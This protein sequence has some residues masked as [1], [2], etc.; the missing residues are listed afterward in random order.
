MAYRNLGQKAHS[1]IHLIS[2]SGLAAGLPT[3]KIVLSLSLMIGVINLLIEAR[4][5]DYLKRCKN[6]KLFF[7]IALLFV[8]HIIG[9]LWT[10]DFQYAMNDI[11]IKIPLL[12]IPVLFIAKPID[13]FQ[14]KFITNIFLATI[15]ITSLINVSTHQHWI[16]NRQYLD[17]RDLSL[18]GSH[19]RYGILIAIATI[20]VGYEMFSEKK[21]ALSPVFIWLI[22]Y[23]YYSQVLSGVLALFAGVIG[24]IFVWLYSKNRLGGVFAMILLIVSLS[25]GFNSIFQFSDHKNKIDVSKLDQYT[26]LG[27]PYTHEV[28]GGYDING[29]PVMLYICEIE[30]ASE[31][32]K[33]ST[34]SID[35][36]DEKKQPIKYTLIRYLA[37]KGLRKDAEGIKKLSETDVHNI[38][39]GKASPIENENTIVARING[40]QFQLVNKGD[41]NGHSLLQR[42]EYW[43]TGLQILKSHWLTGVGTGDV[44][45]AFDLQYVKD[46]SKLK[47]ERRLRSHNQFLTFAIT[48]GIIGF[49]LFIGLHLVYLKQ[50]LS[51]NRFLSVAFIFIVFATFFIEDTLETQTGV[52]LFA[53]FYSF[54]L[55]DSSNDN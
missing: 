6:Q 2:L 5:S 28:D 12:I 1:V 41:P 48:F 18:F 38:E 33:R 32:S 50:A 23:T 42:F 52:T 34:T 43:K 29:N 53:F 16:G 4:F 37:E 17:I 40:L 25:L 11:R 46:N 45:I 15:V 54:F 9:L 55:P 44:Q 10:S 30:M 21:W 13:L 49:L 14:R 8:L 36:L 22:Y 39:S 26:S 24:L 20:L 3:N 27:N 19:I 7:P 35:S 51:D 47:P 31:W